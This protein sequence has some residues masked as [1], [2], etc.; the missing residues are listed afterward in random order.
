MCTFKVITGQKSFR[1]QFEPKWMWSACTSSTSTIV[2]R[3]PTCFQSNFVGRKS[4]QSAA[5]FYH[6]SVAGLKFCLKFDLFY[7][8]L[9]MKKCPSSEQCW[10]P[11]P[12][13][14][15]HESPPI[16]TRPG[17][18]PSSRKVTKQEIWFVSIIFCIWNTLRAK[19]QF[20]KK[21]WNFWME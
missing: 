13:P 11:N 12:R 9:P 20:P 21:L 3:I 5:L 16:S 4:R 10:N 19:Y 8:Y 15:W 6:T 18:P 14:S 7:Y 2:V 1:L 17:L